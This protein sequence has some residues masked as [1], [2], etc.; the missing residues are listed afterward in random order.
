[1]PA[2]FQQLTAA[3]Y[4]AAALVAWAGM[5]QRS[6]RLERVSVGV[7]AFAALMHL[8]ALALLHLGDPPPP[9]TDPA[10]ALSFMAW[11]GTLAFLALLRR[12][13]LAG[14]TVLVAP[15]AFVG[16]FAAALRLPA[17]APA[18][19]AGVGS[20]PHAH[21]LLASAG[22]ALFGLSG[23][24][25][26]L[27]LAEHRRLKAKRP[28]DARLP[29]PSLEALDRVNRVS[30]ALGFPLLTLGVVTGMLW[31]TSERGTPWTGTLH[32]TWSAL[33]WCVCAI[34]VAAR[35]GTHQGSRQAATSAVGG[36]VFLLFA[37]IGVELFA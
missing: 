22:F 31:V 17:A 37:V 13:R 12:T 8:P 19:F 6:A 4:L 11:I 28:L 16:V 34:L 25:G 20:W 24:A 7:L 21:V 1:M 29:L 10:S 27:F 35:F 36:F 14:L 2:L 3:L 30:L 26:V 5:A 33:A 15:V 18:T 9:L 23:L 32:E